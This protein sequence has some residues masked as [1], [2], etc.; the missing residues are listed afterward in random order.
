MDLYFSVW[1]SRAN[2]QLRQFSDCELNVRLKVEK[3]SAMLILEQCGGKRAKESKLQSQ[4]TVVS[5]SL[6]IDKPRPSSHSYNMS[7]A[8]KRIYHL[9]LCIYT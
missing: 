3:C 5:H 8:A 4:L 9:M 2:A 7:F 6:L 1:R